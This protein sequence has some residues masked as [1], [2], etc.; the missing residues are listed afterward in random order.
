MKNANKATD[1]LNS[2]YAEGKKK[3]KPVLTFGEDHFSSLS[4]FNF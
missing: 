4:F 2:P 3:K 1:H